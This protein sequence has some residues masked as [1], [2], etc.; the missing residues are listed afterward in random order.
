M[1]MAIIA[2]DFFLDCLIRQSDVNNKSALY[3]P[4]RALGVP[5]TPQLRVGYVSA[6]RQLRREP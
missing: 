2:T 3:N 1:T 5:L 4:I 6:T